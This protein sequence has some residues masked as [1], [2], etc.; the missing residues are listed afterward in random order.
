M[1]IPLFYDLSDSTTLF[2]GA[3]IFFT[4]SIDMMGLFL[5][6]VVHSYKQRRKQKDRHIV[7]VS[8]VE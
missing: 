5:F 1:L 8:E 6:E 4:C 2:L 3:G 7:K